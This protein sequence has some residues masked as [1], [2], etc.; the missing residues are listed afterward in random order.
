MMLPLRLSSL[1]W[2]ALTHV[3]SLCC[4]VLWMEQREEARLQQSKKVRG[5]HG[6]VT[7]VTP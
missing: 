6:H 5:G 3:M 1:S 2:M 4:N 7:H